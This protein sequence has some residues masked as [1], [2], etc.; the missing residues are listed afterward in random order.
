[1]TDEVKKDSEFLGISDDMRVAIQGNAIAYLNRIFPS[2]TAILVVVGDVKTMMAATF[3]NICS[4]EGMFQLL[5]MGLSNV[6]LSK[7]RGI[8]K[9]HDEQSTGSGHAGVPQSEQSTD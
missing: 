3:S 9:E 2:G 6:F 1:M 8:I 7:G 4:D 5:Q